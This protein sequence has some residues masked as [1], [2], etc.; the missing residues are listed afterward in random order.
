[1]SKISLKYRI[2]EIEENDIESGGLLEVLENVAPV[3]ALS[4]PNAKAIL[5]EIK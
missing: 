5:N 1:M 2:R 3:G 4:K